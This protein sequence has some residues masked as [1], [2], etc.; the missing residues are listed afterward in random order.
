L[1]ATFGAATVSASASTNLTHNGNALSN[2]IGVSFNGGTY[3]QSAATLGTN[4]AGV[5]YTSLN[6]GFLN[7]T[8][9]GGPG[10]SPGPYTRNAGVV[11]SASGVLNTSSSSPSFVELA[12]AGT[13]TIN[14]V[15]TS[16]WV[17]AGWAWNGTTVQSFQAGDGTLTLTN[18]TASSGNFSITDNFSMGSVTVPEGASFT[19]NSQLTLVSDPSS[20]IELGKLSNVPGKL[21]TLGIL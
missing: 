5:S 15:S 9:S 3:L 10:H 6:A 11:I 14:G 21:P 8:S 4:T 7:S 20:L 2:T 16:Y 13:I 19:I 1:P 18:P 12:N 17:V